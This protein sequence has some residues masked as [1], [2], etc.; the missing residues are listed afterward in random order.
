M[1]RGRFI[2]LCRDCKFLDDDEDAG[3]CTTLTAE[4]VFNQVRGAAR[5]A[6]SRGAPRNIPVAFR[7]TSRIRSRKRG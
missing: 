2:R 6:E 3:G 4:I 5:A 7:A 1:D